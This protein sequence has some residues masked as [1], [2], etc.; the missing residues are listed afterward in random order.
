MPCNWIH[1]ELSRSYFVPGFAKVRPVRVRPYPVPDYYFP[2]WRFVVCRTAGAR[3]L[4][5][6]GHMMRVMQSWR[7]DDIQ[8]AS[9]PCLGYLIYAKTYLV[10]H[11]QIGEPTSLYLDRSNCIITGQ[12]V[13]AALG[14][15]PSL[16][17]WALVLQ[18]LARNW[19]TS[20]GPE[21]LVGGRLLRPLLCATGKCCEHDVDHNRTSTVA[22]PKT[23]VATRGS[24]H[25]ICYTWDILWWLQ[26]HQW[27]LLSL[28]VPECNWIG[29]GIVYIFLIALVKRK[30]S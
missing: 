30:I 21:R 22:F 28:L 6:D 1:P 15:T 10:H 14:V 18:Y 4:P 7:S 12:S 11:P 23:F 5:S 26:P 29:H 13:T 8:Y 3:G 17:D 27:H 16:P 25:E 9:Q 20:W 24:P 19:T 2:S